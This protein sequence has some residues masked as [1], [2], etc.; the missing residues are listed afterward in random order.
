[1]RRLLYCFLFLP[2]LLW[3]SPGPSL[4]PII[5]ASRTHVS[6][7]EL[8]SDDGVRA[9]KMVLYRLDPERTILSESEADR[10]LERAERNGFAGMTGLIGDI[11]STYERSVRRSLAI[12]DSLKQGLPPEAK[13]D[14]ELQ[15]DEFFPE[16]RLELRWARIIRF[17]SMKRNMLRSLPDTLA[18]FRK[19]M[20]QN[21]AKTENEVIRAR[22]DNLRN[23]LSPE[24]GL[25]NHIYF[26]YCQALLTRFDP[27]SSVLSE[28]EMMRF[29]KSLSE[30]GESFGLV[31]DRNPLNEIEVSRVLPGGAAWKSG[32]INTRDIVLEAH[33]PD[34][35]RTIYG[36]DYSAREF[37]EILDSES[38]RKAIF[39]IRK[40]GGT[41]IQVTLYKS[42]VR[43]EQ[44]IVNGFVLKG[45]RKIGYIY[46]P[47]FYESWESR[48]APA[49]AS[50]VAAEIVK[51][52]RDGIEGLILD[53]R[54]NGGG[55]LAEAADLCG[56]FID[57]GPLFF[58]K[59]GDEIEVFK[60]PNRGAVYRDP[61]LVLVNE[62][63]ASASEF[64]AGTMKDYNR[65]LIVGRRTFGKATSQRLIPFPDQLVRGRAFLNIT[66]AIFYNLHGESHQGN[67]VE[68]HIALPAASPFVYRESDLP[69]VLD[70]GS[71][72]KRLPYDRL[73]ELPVEELRDRSQD[74]VDNSPVF[75]LID[76]LFDELEPLLSMPDS[77]SLTV[78]EFYEEMTPIRRAL[79]QMNTAQEFTVSAYQASLQSFD[80]G[81][82]DPYTKLLFQ[83]RL[84]SLQ[85]DPYLE[86]SYNI[87]ADYLKHLEDSGSRGR[88]RR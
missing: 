84:E 59:R 64:F 2:V 65:A 39:K 56:L 78:D 80:S 29:Q 63:S 51:L 54:N 6:P 58:G 10:L 86:E 79:R 42:R 85:K 28:P 1:M 44:N 8:E 70:A 36:A 83:E 25:R 33:F 34:K 26:L 14:L 22:I 88:R 67:G 32:K 37:Q 72:D 19:E 18:D 38:S 43:L 69:N 24:E 49:S 5:L 48:D 53:L 27:H 7:P 60:D 75:E 3:A 50:D 74:R 12:L 76:E 47:S 81:S 55:S 61:L 82:A 30:S 9:L 77:I 31:F 66:T 23:S 35:D 21:G 16:A 17:E 62:Q 68:P 11:A 87:M 73:A 41:L 4:P 46:L 52:R 45:K 57:V 13:E 71:I 15:G 20:E 40:P